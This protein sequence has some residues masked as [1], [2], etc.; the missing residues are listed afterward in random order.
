MS[1]NP[2]IFF[3]VAAFAVVFPLLWTGIAVLTARLG[4]WSGL[5]AEFPA[6]GRPDG[7]RYRFASARLRYFVSYRNC[8]TIILSPSGIFL[9][10]IIFLRMGHKPMHVPRAAI[11][12]WKRSSFPLLRSV[13]LEIERRNEDQPTTLTLYGNSLSDGLGEWLARS[14]TPG[15]PGADRDVR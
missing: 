4:G 14:W 8:L 6:T 2:D 13:T 10:P 7:V 9:E 15:R 1:D 12:S 5:A 3:V 11:R